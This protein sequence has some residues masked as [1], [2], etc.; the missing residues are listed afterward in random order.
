M[1]MLEQADLSQLEIERIIFHVVGPEDDDL[2]LMDEVD[3]GHIMDFF[4]TGSGK[5]CRKSV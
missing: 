5:Q 3:L 1:G 4:S 2:V